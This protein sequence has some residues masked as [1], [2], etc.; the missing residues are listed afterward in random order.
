MS[1]LFSIDSPSENNNPPVTSAEK[2]TFVDVDDFSMPH[3]YNGADIT[4][5][6]DVSSSSEEDDNFEVPTVSLGEIV[7]RHPVP[8]YKFSTES[9]IKVAFIPSKII[10]AKFHYFPNMRPPYVWCNGGVCCEYASEVPPVRYIIPVVVLDTDKQG[11]II[12]PYSGDPYYLKLSEKAYTSLCLKARDYQ[13]G[14]VGR[15]ATV[16]CNSTKFQ[17]L[18]FSI[19]D[20]FDIKDQFFS[21][22]SKFINENLRSIA[23]AV[24]AKKSDS[25]I[26]AFFSNS[27]EN[28]QVQ[29]PTANFNQ[30]R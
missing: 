20:R 15:F 27:P 16:I 23:L 9:A 8:P 1:D 5:D 25:E 29:S 24:A 26:R 21:S 17:S 19:L 18:D 12:K 22:H 28:N 7:N 4:G 13:G 10:T 30:R 14:L 6:Y 3:N 11:N 2:E